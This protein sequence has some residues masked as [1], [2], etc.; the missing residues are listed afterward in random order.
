M[1]NDTCT[2]S[3]RVLLP[4]NMLALAF[5][6]LLVTILQETK[7]QQSTLAPAQA[8]FV[9]QLK[10]ID[11]Q[12]T[13]SEAQARQLVALRQH[14][15]GLFADLTVLANTDASAADIV[16]KYGIQYTPPPAPAAPAR[17]P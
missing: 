17:T 9:Q 15:Y 2:C 6:I 8:M 3:G 5:L 12:L 13:Q 16:K 4:F 11:H 7:R 1:S 14:Y 10:S